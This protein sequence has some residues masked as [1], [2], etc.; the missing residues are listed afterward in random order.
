MEG[1]DFRETKR[2]RVKETDREVGNKYGFIT[3][4]LHHC[5]LF[6]TFFLSFLR[7]AH[8]VKCEERLY[9]AEHGERKGGEAIL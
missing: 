1:K 6:Q 4:D 7:L 5:T 9:G 2:W 8:D 3:S